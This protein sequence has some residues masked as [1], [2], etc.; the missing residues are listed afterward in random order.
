MVTPTPAVECHLLGITAVVAGMLFGAPEETPITSEVEAAQAASNAATISGH[1][2]V[3]DISTTAPAKVAPVAPLTPEDAAAAKTIRMQY[4][5]E[6]TPHV[7]I[8][9]PAA[10][11]PENVDSAIR[12]FTAGQKSTVQQIH[13]SAEEAGL[14]PLSQVEKIRNKP[15]PSRF[16]AATQ[17]AKKFVPE[18]QEIPEE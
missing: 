3:H 1:P 8:G 13:G 14:P 11:A 15:E 17:A 7:R 18:T 16:S 2:A 6:E 12:D 10:E 4:R 5:G 9:E